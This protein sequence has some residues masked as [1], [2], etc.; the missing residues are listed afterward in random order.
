MKQAADLLLTNF[1]ATNI[2]D[3]GNFINVDTLLN[4]DLITFIMT[5]QDISLQGLLLAVFR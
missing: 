2:G 1:L 3:L 4:V 5:I